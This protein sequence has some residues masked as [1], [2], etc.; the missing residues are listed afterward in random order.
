VLAAEVARQ[1]ERIGLEIGIDGSHLKTL[2]ISWRC[3]A[4]A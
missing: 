1:D 3:R 2:G 4:E